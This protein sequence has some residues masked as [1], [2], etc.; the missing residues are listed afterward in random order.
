MPGGRSFTKQTYQNQRHWPTEQVMAGQKQA[1][2]QGE[3]ISRGLL[4][5]ILQHEVW[6]FNFMILQKKCNQALKSLGNLF[7]I[8]QNNK[9]RNI[10]SVCH[11]VIHLFIGYFGK[12]N[13]KV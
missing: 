6:L 10:C 4:F 2:K 3:V 13:V 9:E 11:R 7:N 1:P 8:F 5:I 12:P